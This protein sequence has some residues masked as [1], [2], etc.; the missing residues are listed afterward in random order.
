MK[1]YALTCAYISIY[2]SEKY[3]QN[4]SR[5][6]CCIHSEEMHMSTQFSVPIVHFYYFEIWDILLDL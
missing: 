5:Y 1:V 6:T 4:L 3:V 2:L